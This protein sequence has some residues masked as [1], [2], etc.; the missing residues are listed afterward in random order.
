MLVLVLRVLTLVVAIV[1]WQLTAGHLIGILFVSKP[2]LVWNQLKAWAESGALW[3]N[4]WVTIKEILIGYAFGAGAG[5]ALGFALSLTR[6][7]A[8]VL[9]PFV[10]GL[11]AIPKVALAPLFI[12]W[13]G[14]GL[15]MKVILAAVTVFFLV[16]L[17][18][19]AGIKQVDD[20]LIDAARLMG[21][22]T[23]QLILKVVLP[24]SM[25]GVLTGLRIAIPYALI[26]AVIGEL[27]ASNQGLGYLINDSASTLNTAGVY[28]AL[29]ALT[30]IAAVLN[31]VVNILGR[32]TDRWRPND[33]AR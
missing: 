30:V 1:A 26:G 28:A 7:L 9:D 13:F 19:T 18:T 14:I 3:S 32:W 24:G 17:N 33:Q 23:P 22:S 29:V 31:A 10:M 5:V 8:S 12:V 2:T 15:E 11:Y 20:N 16:F 6:V 21:A 4:S 27:V 25:A